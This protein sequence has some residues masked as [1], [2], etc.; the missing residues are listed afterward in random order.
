MKK[1]LTPFKHYTRITLQINGGF[2]RIKNLNHNRKCVF[3]QGH[4]KSVVE[5]FIP[6]KNFNHLVIS[7]QTKA[8]TEGKSH[9]VIAVEKTKL[10]RK[11]IN[12][13]YNNP[14]PYT[15][16]PGV[17]IFSIKPYSTVIITTKDI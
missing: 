6:F 8:K 15:I 13:I 4:N 16:M 10:S 5:P 12:S 7:L 9:T 2:S 3:V 1:L 11:R 17:R 14:A